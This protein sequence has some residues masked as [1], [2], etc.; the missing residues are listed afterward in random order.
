MDES[1]W[2]RKVFR[3]SQIPHRVSDRPEAAELLAAALDIP[4]D[5][6]VV[7]SLATTCV[8]WET[9]PSKVATLQLKSIPVC[10]R[11]KLTDK[12]WPIPVRGAPPSEGLLLLDTHFQGMTVLNDVAAA[13]HHAEYVNFIKRS[14]LARAANLG[15]KLHYY[16]RL[17][18][19]STWVVAASRSR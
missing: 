1:D 12:E 4:A 18:Q 2:I 17:S 5:Q 3:L 11:N 6:I 15:I 8:R 9:P 10:L 13:N 7:Y 14:Y 16:P 19:P